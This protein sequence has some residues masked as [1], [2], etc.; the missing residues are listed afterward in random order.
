[1]KQVNLVVN[2]QH[3]PVAP[4]KRFPDWKT[5]KIMEVLCDGGPRVSTYKQYICKKN[6]YGSDV[7]YASVT[8]DGK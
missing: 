2:E 8:D 6:K 7:T 4:G 1:M 5:W 3:N